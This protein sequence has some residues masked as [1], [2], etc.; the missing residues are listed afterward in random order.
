MDKKLSGRRIKFSIGYIIAAFLIMALLQQFV[1]GPLFTQSAEMSYS[2]FKTALRAGEVESVSVSG[3]Q[4]TGTLKG[5]E[6][7]EGQAFYS[8]RVEDPDLLAELEAQ[9]VE[10]RGRVESEGSFLGTLLGWILPLVLMAGFWYWM[11]G[12]SKSGAGAGGGLF[13]IGKSKAR[14]I[15]GEKTGVTFKDVGGIGEAATL[16]KP[17]VVSRRR[18]VTCAAEWPKYWRAVSLVA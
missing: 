8:I 10:I 11:M 2:D 1:I 17:M 12:R 15:Q 16:A 6:G 18:G 13:S 5:E 4:I 14:V 3:T 7:K 9:G